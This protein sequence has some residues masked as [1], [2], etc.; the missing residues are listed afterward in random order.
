MLIDGL[1]DDLDE[2]YMFVAQSAA[3]PHVRVADLERPALFVVRCSSGLL[4]SGDASGEM[5]ARL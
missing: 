4:P 5:A 3:L 2:D 1:I